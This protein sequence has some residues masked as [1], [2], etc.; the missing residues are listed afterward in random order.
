VKRMLILFSLMGFLFFVPAKLSF[1]QN[2]GGGIKIAV[3]NINFIFRNG[4]AFKSIRDQILKFRETFQGEIQKEEEALRKANQE[5]A[6]QR[7]ILSAEAFAE[8]RRQ[9]EQ[10][11]ADVQRL[12]Q[13]RK[14]NLDKV[15]S[16]A[17]GQVE[18]ALNEIVTAM[19]T[20]QNI[21][22][23]L[24]QEQVV[25]S[26]PELQITQQVLDRLNAKMPT[27][28]VAQPVK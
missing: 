2:A 16:G 26:G 22:L 8:K 23:I 11:V 17:I 3:I 12:V 25:L 5:L 18:K 14:L 20:E 15:N 9:F 7:S 19:A 27:V 6:R 10:S 24:R 21:S 13:S 4:L 28:K 1:A